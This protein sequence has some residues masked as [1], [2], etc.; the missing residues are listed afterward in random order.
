MKDILFYP[1]IL[2]LEFLYAHFSPYAS[3]QTLLNHPCDPIF[4][5]AAYPWRHVRNHF[6]S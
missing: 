1:P 5:R 2:L 4:Q 6:T 3:P